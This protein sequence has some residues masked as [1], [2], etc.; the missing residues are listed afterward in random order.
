MT[1]PRPDPVAPAD[2]SAR[3]LAQTLLAQA[4]HAA[5]AVLDPDGAPFVSRIALGLTPDGAPVTLV[6]ALALHTQALLRD[7]RCALLVGEP[8]DKGDP[9]T[10]P[11]LTVRATARFVARS[12]PGHDPLRAH[13]LATHPKA[14]LYVDFGDFAFVVLAPLSGLLNGGFGQAFAL[15][16][17]DL[18]APR[19]V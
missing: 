10:H 8:G 3:I 7:P 11:R 19:P 6:S 1:Q 14:K 9:L 13:Y 5:I 12:D 16:A 2:Q 15:S 17:D 18:A 4:R